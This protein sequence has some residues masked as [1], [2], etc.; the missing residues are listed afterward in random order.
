MRPI[1]S[2]ILTLVPLATANA[3][4]TYV[5]ATLVNTTFNGAALTLGPPANYVDGVAGN[6]DDLWSYRTAAGFENGETYFETDSG[7][8]PTG[9]VKNDNETT[10]DLITTITLPAAG[11]YQVVALFATNS[12]RDIAAKIGSS[13]DPSDTF[14][15]SNAINA[16]QSV[17][18]PAIVFNES[19][20]NGRG[21][22]AGAAYLGTVT[23]TS[24]NESVAIYINGLATTASLTDDERPQ[25][26]GVAWQLVTPSAP[27]HH[28]VFLFA[29]QS[30]CDGRG[31]VSELTGPLASYAVQQPDV[32]IHYTNPYFLTTGGAANDPLYQKWVPLRPGMSCG[33][34][35]TGALPRNTFGMELAAG[36]VLS[37]HYEHPAIIKV[38]Q[39]GT[40]LGRRGIDW[41][42]APLGSSD[43]GPLYT[44]L[45]TSTRQALQEFTAAGDTYTVHALYW[46]QGESDA[47]RESTYG[48]L[49]TEFIT[50]VRSDLDLPNLRFLVGELAPAKPQSFRDVQW[51]VSRNVHNASFVS[52]INLTTSD[53]NTHFDTGSIIT[54]GKRLGEML[55]ESGRVINF[56]QPAY[57]TGTLNRQDDFSTDPNITVQTT[58]VSGEYPGGQAV[59][60]L[61][62]NADLCGDLRRVLPL[63]NA[64][65]MKADF[66]PDQAD[67]SL[68]AGGMA[69]D[70]NT[71]DRFDPDEAEIG[72]GLGSDGLFHLR[73]GNT[74]H[75]SIGFP[76]QAGHWYRLTVSW[77]V[78]DAG[79]VRQV[80]LR[81]RDLTSAQDINDGAA[82]I[83]APLAAANP[84]RWLGL[85]ICAN[86]GLLD[87]LGVEAPGFDGWRQNRFPGIQNDPTADDDGDGITNGFEYLLGL[88]PTIPDPPGTA[89]S[90][91]LEANALSLT[92]PEIARAEDV[93]VQVDSSSDLLSWQ[94]IPGLAVPGAI[95]FA[96]PIA[97]EPRM[98]LRSRL[99]IS[100]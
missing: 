66:Y 46:H 100:R 93:L 73:F 57:D 64:R 63:N 2:I 7:K 59:G 45:I 68:L 95:R 18:S 37:Q 90:P 70:S 42:P 19:Y 65:E 99:V 21:T 15:I 35:I 43:V 97:N 83:S 32:L 89:P 74:L 10:P 84:A 62:T 87:N 55:T 47:S 1:L 78:P 60:N 24:A 98:F 94:A 79:G 44:A 13:P 3:S 67:S 27:I 86:R 58:S 39:G 4:Y 50:R 14:T 38:T 56:E 80:S 77:T 76:Y 29:G 48:A 9:S 61:V 92:Q 28:D 30:N 41:Y 82:V 5:D 49:L 72:M 69:S 25:Y 51:R 26:D 34:G 52:S 31:A 85:G 54:Y 17:P 20:S 88:D 96:V 22:N 6:E 53:A 81:V 23:T 12:G 71:N 11:T 16:N 36:P 40:A 91:I 75:P 8:P 33:P